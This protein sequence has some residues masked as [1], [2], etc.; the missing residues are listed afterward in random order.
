VTPLAERLSS[1]IA[2]RGPLS[3]ARFM[4]RALYDPEDGYYSRGGRRIGRRG[5]FFTASDVG[6]LFG[7][8]MARQVREIDRAIGPLDS[9]HVVEFGAG[10]GLL[11]RDLLDSME[12]LDAGLRARL[13]YVMV[14]RSREML[15][16]AARRVPEAE[17]LV[18]P[19]LEPGLRGCALAVELFDALPVHRVRRRDGELVEVWVDV[20]DAGA[21]VE[22]EG[23]CTPE[24]RALAE[25]YGAAAEEGT[26]AEVAPLATL[27][28]DLLER[29]LERGVMLVVDYGDRAERLYGP[30]R[31]AGTLLAYRRHA[32][33]QEYL[34]HVGEQDLTAHVNFSAV[35]DRAR[36]LGLEPLGLTTQDRFLIANGIL[37]AFEQDDPARRCS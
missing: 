37:D 28:V 15:A 6:P 30:A 18:P 33:S 27:Q 36:A 23:P 16:E 10:R 1:E 3:F 31:P 14:D 24:A 25:R 35:E 26:E 13:R 4:E 34:A 22:S 5:D 17:C 2:E 19:E 9:F 8:A 7:A 21:L 11:A 32:T 12:D 20:D 29:S